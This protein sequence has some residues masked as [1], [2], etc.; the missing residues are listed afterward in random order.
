MRARILALV[1]LFGCADPVQVHPI[2]S[3][4][5]APLRRIVLMPIE[6]PP[7]P[8]GGERR[9]DADARRV[10]T[11]RMTEALALWCGTPYVG[12]VE[13]EHW[14]KADSEAPRPECPGA[15]PSCLPAAIA[16]VF[17]ADAL[18]YVDVQRYLAREGSTASV[19]RPASVWLRLE[20]RS[21]ANAPLWR[22]EYN[23]T[24]QTLS[25]DLTSWSRA[26]ERGFRWVSAETLASYGSRT[27]V[28]RLDTEI[29]RWK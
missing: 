12:P 28:Q 16:R 18:L 26:Y 6:I 20:L 5:P 27:L 1:I 13:V 17:S 22:G 25:E 21:S 9:I 11:S 24:Q 14:I 8:S 15:E 19:R 3:P 7:T 23:E 10:V 4:P 29:R 2:G